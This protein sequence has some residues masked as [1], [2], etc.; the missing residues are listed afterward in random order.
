ME[1]KLTIE[2]M[3]SQYLLCLNGQCSKGSRS[4]ERKVI[5]LVLRRHGVMG[6]QSSMIISTHTT[7]DRLRC[8][9]E[10]GLTCRWQYMVNG[11]NSLL[12]V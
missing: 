11:I 6:A 1:E 2:A 9:I 4:E 5:L 12:S 10:G 8:P 7:N 3:P